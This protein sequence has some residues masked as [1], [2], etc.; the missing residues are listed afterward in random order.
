MEREIKPIINKI[1][2]TIYTY[3]YIYTRIICYSFWLAI[4]YCTK[5][6][7]YAKIM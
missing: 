1:Y 2:T 3:I 7:Y 5:Y 6:N 4:S